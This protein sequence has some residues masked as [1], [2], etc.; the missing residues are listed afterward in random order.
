[1]Y[2]R[3]SP[4]SGVPIET[5]EPC[6]T[7]S[8]RGQA[9]V[10][11]GIGI[12]LLVL[13]TLSIVDAARLFY[14]YLTLQDGVTQATR[15]AVTGQQMDNPSNP[16][17]KLSREDSIRQ[18]MHNLTPG[19]PIDD[20]DIKFW[21]VTANKAGAGDHDDIIQVTVTHRP[22]LINPMLWPF[23]GGNGV[24]TLQVSSTMKNEPFPN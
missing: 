7:P 11:T 10:E 6:S 22:Q 13:V 14:I 21:D 9:L 5:R 3:N 20:G 19:I 16:S 12:V 15:Y 17:G 23:V 18:V 2:D 1:M 8:R 24:I 4:A